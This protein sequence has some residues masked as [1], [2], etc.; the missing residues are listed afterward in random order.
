MKIINEKDIEFWNENGY[1]AVENIIDPER[2]DN[3]LNLCL[4]YAENNNNKDLLEMPGIHNK[5]PETFDLMKDE[6]VLSIVETILGGESIG[7]NTVCVFKKAGTPSAKHA[8]NPHQ[9]GT[10]IDIDEDK[11]CGGNIVLDDHLP[12]SGCLYVYPGSH[13]E[14]LLPYEP[15]ISFNL[16][17]NTNPGNKV[18]DIP[19]KYKKVDLHLKK[20]SF[21]LLHYKIIHGSYGNTSDHNWRPI[22]LQS[23]IRSDVKFYKKNN[24]SP[25]VGKNEWKDHAAKK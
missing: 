17:E 5:I 16:E 13:L 19:K 22:L 18:I 11:Y 10:Y 24:T 9:D 15:N 23:Y 20:G 1:L 7:L 12:D 6:K 4:D 2:C 25:V 14:E 8:W 21:L 3:Y